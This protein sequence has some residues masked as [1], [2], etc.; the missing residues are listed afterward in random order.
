[1]LH[2]L[3]SPLNLNRARCYKVRYIALAKLRTEK[4]KISDAQLLTGRES[5]SCV[6]PAGWGQVSPTL[7]ACIDSFSFTWYLVAAESSVQD[8][9][10]DSELCSCLKAIEDLWKVSAH[11]LVWRYVGW[12]HQH[13]KNYNLHTKIYKPH[14]CEA[15]RDSIFQIIK[16]I[17]DFESSKDKPYINRLK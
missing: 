6:S 13:N 2:I 14:G 1:M 10:Q 11:A 3:K 4:F 8:V 5:G 12:F 9:Q 7:W 16:K 15:P 17:L